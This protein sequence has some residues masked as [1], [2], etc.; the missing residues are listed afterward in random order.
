MT[1]KNLLAPAAAV[2][3]LFGIAAG[4]D[5]A[6]VTYDF[7]SGYI[8]LSADFGGVDLLPAG[9]EIP[10]TG[11]Q[12]T[13]NTTTLQLSSFQFADAGPTTVA[14]TGALAG[15]SLTVSGL[16]VVPGTGY[17]TL[18]PTTGTDPYDFVVGPISASGLYG[19]NGA[20]ATKSFSGSNPTLSGLITI[21]GG[22]GTDDLTLTGITLGTFAAKVG[23]VM[24][25]VTLKGDVVFNGA[26][27]VPLP[28]AVWLLVSGLGMLG[29]PL[30]RRRARVG[31]ALAALVAV[32]MS[33]M[34]PRAALAATV[35]VTGGP[36]LDQGTLCVTGLACPANPTF[37]L[38]GADPVTGSFDYN[39]TSHMVD[40]TLT[41][42]TSANFGGETLLA[43]STFAAASVPVLAISLG[44]GAVEIT[45]NGSASGLT[46][47]N[48]TPGLA[49]ILNAP[50]I[51]GLTCTIGTGSDQC[52]VSFGAAGLELGP[53]AHGVDYNAFLTI[54]ANVDPVPLPAAAWLM[55]GGLGCLAGIR[56]KRTGSFS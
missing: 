6:S 32:P 40:F 31:M 24:E 51:S 18:S 48:F 46:S 53:D 35:G 9:Q 11:T 36:G 14:L 13:F 37:S 4:A 3:G 43:G 47:L 8:T 49:S 34:A 54:N 29:A 21:A 39:S 30:L 55:L 2:F 38:V 5:A 25:N 16:N 26:T 19:V 56:R 17:A 28:A 41:L 22:G 42:S 20:A 52:G 44:G 15:N 45:Q 12:V 27:P 23:G 1:F 33:M 10:L 7:T 50:T